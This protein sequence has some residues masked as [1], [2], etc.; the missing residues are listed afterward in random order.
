[1]PMILQRRL[2]T[3]LFALLPLLCMAEGWTP[4]TLPMVHLQDAR[5]Y[6]CNPDGV[7]SQAAVDSTDAVLAR[8]ERDK[9][10]QTVVVAVK[11][12]EG[13]DPYRFGMELGRKYGVGDAE[14]RT[15]LIIVLSTEDRAYQFLTGNGLEGALPDAVCRRIQNRVMV[16]AL[17]R[18]DWDEAVF[19]SVKAADGYI[20]GD[21]QLGTGGGDGTDGPVPYLLLGLVIVGFSVFIFSIMRASLRN[22]PRCGSKHCMRSLGMT[23]FRAADGRRRRR[24]TWRCAKCG[25]EVTTDS[26]DPGG[27]HQSH[28]GRWMGPVIFGSGRGF[29]GGGSFGGGHFG[30]GS[31]GGGGSGGRF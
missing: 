1:M 31:F 13:G 14:E 23:F 25:Y 12:I 17:K 15:G 21:E 9:G 10:V 30:G 11:R 27:R 8:L 4:E 22:C 24:I 29:G 6:V 16:P 28:G 26:D 3:L 7:M 20:R 19:A 18:G 2:F 5:R